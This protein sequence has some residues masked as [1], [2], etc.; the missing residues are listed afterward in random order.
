MSFFF[1]LSNNTVLPT[2]LFSRRERKQGRT[3]EGRS[4][5]FLR[6]PNLSIANSSH[7]GPLPGAQGNG[8]PN[9]QGAGQA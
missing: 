1:Y 6:C 3:K 2:L 5:S 4:V 9:I 8:N 7:L